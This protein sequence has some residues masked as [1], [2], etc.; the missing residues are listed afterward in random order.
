MEAAFTLLST[1]DGDEIAENADSVVDD[2]RPPLAVPTQ[3][4]RAET[5]HRRQGTL[6]NAPADLADSAPP[7]LPRTDPAAAS[8]Q[9][10]TVQAAACGGPILAAPPPS[11]SVAAPLPP[12]AATPL[13]PAA[14]AALLPVVTA[15]LA[16]VAAVPAT[17]P[18]GRVP[19]VEQCDSTQ[20][21]IV[22]KTAAETKMFDAAAAMLAAQGLPTDRKSVVRMMQHATAR[23]TNHTYR[24]TGATGGILGAEKNKRP[25]LLRSSSKLCRPLRRHLLLP[26][27]VPSRSRTTVRATC[28]PWRAHSHGES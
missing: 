14:A 6:M 15:P 28:P 9:V 24:T 3:T 22:H 8:R 27:S 20:R 4:R 7:P 23:A 1:A 18:A 11:I 26:T 5:K 13:L 10:P 21:G 16:P 17:G 12:N 2:A 25:H 19:L